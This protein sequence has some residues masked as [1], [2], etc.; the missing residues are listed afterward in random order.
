[1]NRLKLQFSGLCLLS[2]LVFAGFTCA[3]K[4]WDGIVPLITT[5]DQVE[6]KIGRPGS[7]G[8]YEF[9]DGRVL[10]KYVEVRCGKIKQ[11]DCLVPPGTVQFVRVE[12]Y[13]DLYI[14]D[15]KL[16]SKEFKKTRNTHQPELFTYANHKR[17]IVY[18]TYKGKVSH[19]TYYGSEATCKKIERLRKE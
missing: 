5:K 15:L 3:Q 11:C 13:Y 17:G 1:M 9:D 18:S 12:I 10:V 8:F 19:I 4:P 6:K 2:V 14:K 7:N 16:D